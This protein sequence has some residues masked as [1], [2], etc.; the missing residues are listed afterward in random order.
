MKRCKMTGKYTNLKL[1][2]SMVFTIW[3]LD[4]VCINLVNKFSSVYANDVLQQISDF[5]FITKWWPLC[6]YGNMHINITY[7]CHL[8][9]KSPG[10]D[11]Y[12]E[13]V[14][15]LCGVLWASDF[16]FKTLLN[17]NALTFYMQLYKF[18]L[19]LTKLLLAI[20]FQN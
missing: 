4:R 11:L 16:F 12:N 14:D 7:T 10:Y 8:I 18:T 1:L 13:L 19:P 17:N 6:C 5:W 20:K 2:D 15:R 9:G 3:E